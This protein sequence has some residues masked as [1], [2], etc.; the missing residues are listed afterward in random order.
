MK[1]T[2]RHPSNCPCG[3]KWVGQNEDGSKMTCLGNHAWEYQE[4]QWRQV[5]QTSPLLTK[6]AHHQERCRD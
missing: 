2:V 3:Q 5:E 6:L 4:G 1:I